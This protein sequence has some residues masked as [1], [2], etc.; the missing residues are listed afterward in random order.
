MDIVTDEILQ[1][2]ITGD[3]SS[4]EEVY[5]YHF[6]R[7]N[8][9][10][11]QYLLDPEAAKNVVQDVFTEL[12]DKRHTLRDDTNLQAWLFTVTKNKSLKIISKLRSRQ[13][14]D[15]FIKT[16]ELDINYKALSKFDTNNF[17]FEELQTQI[18]IALEKLSPACRRVF[19]LSRFKDKKNREIAEELNLSIKT[20]E[21]HISK[22]LRSLKEDLKDYL[23]LFYILF[24]FQK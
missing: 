19:E 21:G 24:L 9:F 3:E 23:L 11:K 17:I 20:V 5:R 12:W 8:Y 7:L 10:A 22:A 18:Q 2:I 16:R 15:N 13:N 1:K 6:P 14:Y 4:F